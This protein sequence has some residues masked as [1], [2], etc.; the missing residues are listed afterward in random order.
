M[1]GWV[2][3]M[4]FPLPRAVASEFPGLEKGNGGCFAAVLSLA[5]TL[6]GLRRFGPLLIIL[7]VAAC[8]R[9][10]SVVF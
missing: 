9:G 10:Q 3:V 4:R 1:F 5:F 2:I 8:E 6:L 7:Q